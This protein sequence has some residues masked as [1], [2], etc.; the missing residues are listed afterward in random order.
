MPG[1]SA[2]SPASPSAYSF[3]ASWAGHSAHGY[4]S[5]YALTT[6]NSAGPGRST[7]FTTTQACTGTPAAA[8][9]AT[10][11]PNASVPPVQGA[12]GG[13]S[14]APSHRSVDSG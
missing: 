1:S 11:V 9:A 3:T 6:A 5:P 7:W 12:G 10:A 2:M 14:A 8:S 13:S 4:R